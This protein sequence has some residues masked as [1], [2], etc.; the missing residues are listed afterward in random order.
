MPSATQESPSVQSSKKR[1]R[2]D[3]TH[4]IPLP[5]GFFTKSTLPGEND[6]IFSSCHA[7]NSPHDIF[8]QE[9]VDH[10]PLHHHH[11]SSP[12]GTDKK[13]TTTIYKS[14]G[15]DHESRLPS[16]NFLMNRCHICSRKPQKKSDFDSFADCHGCGQRTCYVCIRECLGWGPPPSNINNNN[17]T[18]DIPPL[19]AT[20][21]TTSEDGDASFTMLDVDEV[22]GEG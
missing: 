15:G 1:R 13:H 9:T 7:I 8:A 11:L 20:S 14:P 19:A 18:T 10:G 3:I 21:T 17:N 22:A 4:Q 2:D 16:T 12:Q 5:A 6:S